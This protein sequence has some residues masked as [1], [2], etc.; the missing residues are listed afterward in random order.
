MAL[1]VYFEASHKLNDT[2][3]VIKPSSLGGAYTETQPTLVPTQ[4]YLARA[5]IRMPGGQ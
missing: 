1:A 4:A 5:R 3:K 2:S